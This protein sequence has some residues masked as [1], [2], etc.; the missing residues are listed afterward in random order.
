MA[1]TRLIDYREMKRQVDLLGPDLAERRLI[2]AFEKKHLGP[3][4]FTV[5]ELAEAFMGREWVGNLRPKSGRYYSVRQLQEADASAVAFSQFSNVTGQWLFAEVK[6][7]WEQE[8]LVFSKIIPEKTT[9][10]LGMELIPSMSLPSDEFTV[11]PEGG[12]YP[13]SGIS[14]D[15][16]HRGRLQ[17]RGDVI[18]VTKECILS[19]LTG[20]LLEHAKKLGEMLAVNKEKRLIDCCIDEGAGAV[21][22]AL[23]GGHR[24]YWKNTSY[25]TYQATTPWVNIRA[26]NGLVDHTDIDQAW[27][28]LVQMTDP[29]T[30][31]P[32]RVQAKHLI[33]TPQNLMT[34]WRIK[35]TT[36]VATHAGGYAVTGD[37]MATDAP[38][39]INQVVGDLQIVSSQQLAARA[40]TDTDWWL[41]DLAKA[42]R[43]YSAWSVSSEE[44]PSN[45]HEAFTRDII[46]QHKVSEM[47]TAATFDPRYMVENQA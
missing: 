20:L 27:L 17:K 15:F 8:D 38:S 24:Y 9:K 36:N 33:V 41:G 12:E 21:S 44:A 3:H 4:D 5:A 47:G 34:A 22:A 10:V 7:G 43:Y 13:Q 35:Q 42:F 46:F 6:A 37:L 16:Q 19:D 23:S 31:E 32:L 28:R 30:G 29:Y 11:I 26:A 39:P 25:A 45:S 14:E 18:P 1:G 40:A 2:E